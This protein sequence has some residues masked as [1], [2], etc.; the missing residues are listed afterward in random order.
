[1][2]N[3]NG[4]T[5][6]GIAAMIRTGSRVDGFK[7]GRPKVSIN[8][9][10]PFFVLVKRRSVVLESVKFGAQQNCKIIPK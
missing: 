8:I 9:F 5:H 2:L 10:G 7:I 4:T 6:N 3:T 1:M